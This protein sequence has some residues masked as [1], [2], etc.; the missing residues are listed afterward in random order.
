VV[1]I[2]IV[3]TL[4]VLGLLYLALPLLTTAFLFVLRM[5]WY[6]ILVCIGFR[7][8]MLLVFLATRYFYAP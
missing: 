8:L 2:W 5:L 1:L 4:V 7:V 6:F 3:G